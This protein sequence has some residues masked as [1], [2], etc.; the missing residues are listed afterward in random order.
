MFE[1]GELVVF[2]TDGVCMVEKVGALEM[3]GVAKDKQYYTLSPVGKKGSNHIFA[4]V[5][6]KRVVMRRVLSLD[7]A[8]N[9]VSRLGDIG[10]LEIPDERK[11]E[12]T[13][14]A[15]LQSCDYVKITELI[16]EIYFRRKTRAAAGKKL[17]S[18]DERYF[19]AA[20][21]SLYSELGVSLNMEKDEL[22]SF[23][24]KSI[25]ET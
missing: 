24:E 15:V 9:F 23:M 12:D 3:E 14:K 1:V 17:P 8:K 22:R 13:Y 25:D 20:E 16:K 19:V 11:R 18:V 21:N 2:G 4:P 7:E 6:G 5:D 10:R